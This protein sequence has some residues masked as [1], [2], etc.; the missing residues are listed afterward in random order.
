MSETDWFGAGA[1][2][3]QGSTDPGDF[4]ALDDQEAQRRWLGG[5]GAAWP[6]AR[7]K[8]RT[9]ATGFADAPRSRPLGVPSPIG[10]SCASGYCSTA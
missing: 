6:S 9:E 2:V 8:R 1:A 3:F 5:F 10:P 7:R 4:P